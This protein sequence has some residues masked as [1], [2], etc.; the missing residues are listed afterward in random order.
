MKNA[1]LNEILRIKT[2]ILMLRKVYIDIESHGGSVR[3]V[4]V[5][6]LV[7]KDVWIPKV[8]QFRIIQ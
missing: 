8:Y 6:I 5:H 1:L 3:V 4:N 2:N 7:Q